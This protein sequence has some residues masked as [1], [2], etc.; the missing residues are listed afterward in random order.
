MPAPRSTG[1]LALGPRET[2][3]LLQ[4]LLAARPD[5]TPEQ[6]ARLVA[7]AAA[8]N[9]GSPGARRPAAKRPANRR[10]ASRT[11]ATRQTATEDRTSSRWST[12]LGV[13]AMSTLLLPAAA[14]LALP[15]ADDPDRPGGPVDV[16]EVALSTQT[17][18]LA[19]A[20]R[21]RALEQRVAL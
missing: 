12:R 17:S 7:A 20:D 3:A 5:L 13:V 1:R 9:A 18:L 15:G 11:R 2:Q 6:A 14:V 10:P 8:K 4:R 21:Y 16:T 19:Q